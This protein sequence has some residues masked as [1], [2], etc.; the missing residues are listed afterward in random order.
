MVGGFV[1][2]GGEF[3]ECELWWNHVEVDHVGGWFGV[4]DL[5]GQFELVVI[6][7]DEWVVVFMNVRVG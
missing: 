5:R 7:D 4:V 6:V 2:G 1:G 3:V